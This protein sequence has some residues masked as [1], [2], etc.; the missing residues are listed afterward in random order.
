MYES[1]GDIP[2]KKSGPNRREAERR[3]AVAASGRSSDLFLE[4]VEESIGAGNYG[5]ARRVEATVVDANRS[6]G[7]RYAG[8]YV[9]KDFHP[10]MNQKDNAAETIRKHEYFRS[11]G[12]DTWRTVRRLEGRDSVLMTDGEREGAL[13]ITQNMSKSLEL[14]SEHKLAH[15]DNLYEAVTKGLDNVLLADQL[16]VRIPE[17]AWM[18]NLD[19]PLSVGSDEN[20]NPT[21]S[22]ASDRGGMI[23]IFIGDFDSFDDPQAGKESDMTSLEGF[24]ATVEFIFHATLD[25]SAWRES[26]SILDETIEEKCGSVENSE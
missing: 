1:F 6:E 23:R 21:R 20:G 9:I 17:D 24:R 19:V 15:I 16:G 25:P 2:S 26:Q 13:I 14:F 3:T 22:L 18:V 11:N 8:S 5:V 4:T 12:F 10:W 7:G